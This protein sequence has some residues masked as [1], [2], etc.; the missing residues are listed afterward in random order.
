MNTKKQQATINLRSR[1]TVQ[2]AAKQWFN[3]MLAQ[4]KYE[5][6]KDPGAFEENTGENINI[7]NL[8]EIK[9]NQPLDT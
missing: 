2:H 7:T 3:L 6:S 9:W 1:P 8:N 5:E 4:V